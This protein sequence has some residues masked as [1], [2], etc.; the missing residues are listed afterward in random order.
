MRQWLDKKGLCKQ[1]ER[2]RLGAELERDRTFQ[3]AALASVLVS[4][5]T[6]D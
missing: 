1:R 6:W 4:S 2:Q 3:H 5:V